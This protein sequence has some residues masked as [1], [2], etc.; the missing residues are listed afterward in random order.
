MKA[1]SL[2]KRIYAVLLVM[3][4]MQGM[5]AQEIDLLISNG[6]IIDPKSNSDSSL[7]VAVALGMDLDHQP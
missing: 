4:I 3:F 1:Y 6:H 7:D 2:H 5:M